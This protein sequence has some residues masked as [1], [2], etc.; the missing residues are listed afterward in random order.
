MQTI[1]RC[2]ECDALL[3]NGKTCQDDFHQMLF[4]EAEFPELWVVHHL[5]V[6]CYHL[7]HPSLY[8][9]DGL[10]VSKNLL[11]EFIETNITPAEVIKRNQVTL[12]SGKRDFKIKAKPGL[13]GSYAHPVK[14]AMTAANITADGSDQYCDNVRAWAQSMYDALK[15][16]GNL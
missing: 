10:T 1:T 14:W 15:E 6:L 4:W 3:T 12:N 13:Q 5:M 7:Q 8:A 16:S 11:A 2:S 9:P